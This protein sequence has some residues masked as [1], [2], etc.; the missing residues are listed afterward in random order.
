[1]AAKEW[2]DSRVHL[3]APLPS[4]HEGSVSR[5]PGVVAAI[6]ATIACP[7]CVVEGLHYGMKLVA[8]APAVRV[9]KYGF[10]SLPGERARDAAFTAPRPESSNIAVIG[11]GETH[12]CVHAGLSGVADPAAPSFRYRCNETKP[13]RS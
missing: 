10:G 8:A 11:R 12:A 13:R 9:A 7:H 2:H 4:S 3:F 1:L 5:G 6:G